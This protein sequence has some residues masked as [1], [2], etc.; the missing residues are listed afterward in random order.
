MRKKSSMIHMMWID[1]KN[2]KECWSL[3]RNWSNG[4]GRFLL[5]WLQKIWGEVVQADLNMLS[6]MNKLTK[7]QDINRA[8]KD[9]PISTKIQFYQTFSPTPPHSAS[10]DPSIILTITPLT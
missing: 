9:L 10:T 3:N 4:R 7:A 1:E 8:W 2:V 5:P 6:T